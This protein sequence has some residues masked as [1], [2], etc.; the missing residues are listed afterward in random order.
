ML[1]ARFRLTQ[2]A[3]TAYYRFYQ[4]MPYF[5]DAS[6]KILAKPIDWNHIP[7]SS[8]FE[9]SLLMGHHELDKIFKEE[10]NEIVTDSDIFITQRI[11]GNGGKAFLKVIR[12]PLPD[13]IDETFKKRSPRVAMITDIDDAVFDLPI[14]SHAYANYEPGS[15]NFHGFNWQIN[16]SDGI[17]VS[18]EYLKKLC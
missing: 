1:K 8:F 2:S 18:T 6:L 9:N 3:A 11:H 17:T 16:N 13:N 15:P 7:Q 14:Y 4:M 10:F 5:K 12:D